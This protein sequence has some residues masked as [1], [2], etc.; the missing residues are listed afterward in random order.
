MASPLTFSQVR[1]SDAFAWNP[2]GYLYVAGD[3]FR[4]VIQT[5][6][7]SDELA[8]S[9]AK[10]RVRH[11]SLQ[12][13]DSIADTGWRHAE[14]CQC[15]ACAGAPETQSVEI[16]AMFVQVAQYMTRSGDLV[17]LHGLSEATLFFSDRPRR[18]VGHLSTQRFV[19]EWSVGPNNFAVDPPNAVISFVRADDERPEDAT[20]VI[21]EPRL[22]GDR[23]TYGVD[24]LEGS[25]P[26]M[27][28]SCS[29]FIDPVARP[30]S[31]A[32]L[33]GMRRRVKRR[34]W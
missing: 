25:L 30:L 17:T 29:L 18:I 16:A 20:V 8:D 9:A 32:S 4:A 34:G 7:F 1:S 21:R 13:Q 26:A 12:E 11:S 6:P 24:L 33:A 3:L 27:A 15:G 23:I 10:L 5:R 31:P 19:E 2:D 22:D 28:E 14:D